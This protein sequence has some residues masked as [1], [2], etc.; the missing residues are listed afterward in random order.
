MRKF[1]TVTALFM[2]AVMAFSF[3]G[4]GKKIKFYNQDVITKIF[5]D[6]LDIDEDEI[7]STEME[8]GQAPADCLYITTRYNDVRI[9][10][11]LF[12][13]AEEALETFEQKYDVF[14]DT[15]DRQGIF[16]GNYD[17]EFEDNWGYIVVNGENTSSGIFGDIYAT[18]SVYAGIYFV[19]SM[20]VTVM[21]EPGFD[22]NADDIDTVLD[23][24]GYPKA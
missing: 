19:D 22:I 10:V 6:K 4:C 17:S 5:E 13:E 11:I 18:G 7:Y 21:P 8:K 14:N 9:N 20:I 12:D 2:T 23:A 3:A 16:E 24:L 15:F 1:R